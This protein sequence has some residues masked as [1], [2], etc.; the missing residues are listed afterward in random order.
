MGRTTVFS[1]VESLQKHLNAR[2]LTAVGYVPTMGAL[3]Q[4]HVS[5][6]QMSRERCDLTV[7]SIFVNPTQFNNATDLEKYPRTL[8]SDLALLEN[9]DD[10]VVFTPS[11]SE[12][13]PEN[14][15][16]KR[17]DLGVLESVMEGR[18]RQGHFDGVVEV[19]SRL[20]DIVKPTVAFF[21]EKDFQQLAVI[22]KM[23]SFFDL[24][25]EIVGC[26]IYREPSGLASS[27]R[28]QRLTEEQKEEAL[29]IYNTLKTVYEKRSEL[30]PAEAKAWAEQLFSKSTLRLEYFE[31]VNQDTFLPVDRWTSNVQACVA[32][33]CGEVR[34]ID[35]LSMA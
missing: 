22:R 30:T 4:G 2:S 35:N 14:H 27:S 6:V 21:G 28:N 8:E 32:A 5:L 9:F 18:F 25:I 26:P 15:V 11:V 10:V 33:Y 31:F 1:T 23:V 29:I 16:P 3:H 34:L 13:Y 12:I 17:V 19:V 24:P 20:F 7:V